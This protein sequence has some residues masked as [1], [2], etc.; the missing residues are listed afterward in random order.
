MPS[1]RRAWPVPTC[2]PFRG[3]TFLPWRLPTLASGR[4]PSSLPDPVPY[5]RN[6]DAMNFEPRLQAVCK[7]ETHAARTCT[8]AILT[9]LRPTQCTSGQRGGNKG[10][11]Q[12]M[13]EPPSAPRFL[14]LYGVDPLRP[15][16]AVAR[17]PPSI[18]AFQTPPSHAVPILRVRLLLLR[19]LVAFRPFSPRSLALSHSGPSLSAL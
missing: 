5:A 12:G 7:E 19:V 8:M 17:R 10:T 3:G 9:H 15:N 18:C 13:C 11:C 6:H 2:K 1:M 14:V 16:L 4:R